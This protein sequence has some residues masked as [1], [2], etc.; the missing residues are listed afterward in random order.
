MPPTIRIV[1]LLMSGWIAT[2]TTVMLMLAMCYPCSHVSVSAPL[3]YCS[4]GHC[5]TLAS[6]QSHHTGNNLSNTS[7]IIMS[8]LCNFID[9]LLSTGNESDYHDKLFLK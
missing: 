2:V 5:W 9:Q 3:Q 4:P 1:Y 7:I 6:C 8:P